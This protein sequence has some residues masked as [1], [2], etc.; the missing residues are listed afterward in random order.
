MKTSDQ[1][2]ILAIK[3]LGFL[4]AEPDR[5]ERFLTLSGMTAQMVREAAGSNQFLKGVLEHILADES[6]LLVFCTE[7]NIPP[8]DIYPVARRLTGG[9]D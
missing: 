3:A 9:T 1:D 8:E 5:F 4:A 2:E 7:T 6:L